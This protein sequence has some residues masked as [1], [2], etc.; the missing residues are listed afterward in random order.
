GVGPNI[1]KS[2]L[3]KFKTIKSIVNISKEELKEIENIGPKKAEDII[4]LF[5]E[6][7]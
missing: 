6:K 3:K 7:Y 4:K 1:A 2:L 5:E